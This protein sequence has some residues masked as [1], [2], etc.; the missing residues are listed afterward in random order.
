MPNATSV[1]ETVRY[2]LAFLFIDS[3][4]CFVAQGTLT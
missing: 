3:G 1:R 4:A 2:N